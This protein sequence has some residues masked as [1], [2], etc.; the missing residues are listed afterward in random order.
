MVMAMLGTISRMLDPLIKPKCV[1]C[2]I[3]G[4]IVYA[5]N[6]IR[7]LASSLLPG[8]LSGNISKTGALKKFRLRIWRIS[9]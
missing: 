5:L 9:G 3:A 2:S 1:S 8:F 6:R 7:R 4:L